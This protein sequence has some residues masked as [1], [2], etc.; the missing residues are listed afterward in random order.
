MLNDKNNA[1]LSKN[2]KIL[3]VISVILTIL[4]LLSFTRI[5][6]SSDKREKVKTALVNQKY[7]NSIQSFELSDTTGS[8]EIVN[9]GSFWTV[10]SVPAS[11]ERI[12]NFIENLT[13][14][15]NLYKISDKISQKSS[16]GL[17][18]GT[19]FHIRYYTSD[20]FHE[21]IFGNQDYS[22]SS[23]YMMTEK[24]TQ[25]YEIDNSLDSYLTTLIQNWAEP[26]ILSRTAST[27]SDIQKVSVSYRDEQ[28]RTKTGTITD[29]EKLRELRHGGIPEAAEYQDLEP[30]TQVSEIEIENG[31]KTKTI[32]SIYQKDS[33]ENYFIVKVSYFSADSKTPYY[34][35]YSKISTWTYNKIR[36]ITL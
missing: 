13:T 27:S 5:F 33:N 26:Y 30:Q 36:E 10:N 12:E 4:Y 23:R 3:I 25:V 6:A 16:F 18:P 19:E 21:L 1:N 2:S 15:R 31:N 7:I 20:G 32:I 17:T 22:L 9:N 29:V 24:T 34:I 28:G 11:K 14:I 35:S 8:L